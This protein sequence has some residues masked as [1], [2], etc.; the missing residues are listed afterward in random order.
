MLKLLKVA[1]PP[2]PV[3]TV[4]VPPNAAVPPA[5]LIVTAAPLTGLPPPSSSFITTAGVIGAPAGAFV[6]C[7]IK[8]IW[9]APLAMLVSA[10]LALP[11]TPDTVAVMT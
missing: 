9:L 1:S 3:V 11:E 7:W 5:R 6:G 4:N 8:L 2:A 10:K